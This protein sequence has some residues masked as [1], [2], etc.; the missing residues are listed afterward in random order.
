LPWLSLFL[1]RLAG[2]A[3]MTVA[4][5]HISRLAVARR[6][7]LVRLPLY[8]LL[9]SR[10]VVHRRMLVRLHPYRLLLSRVVVAS[11]AMSIAL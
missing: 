8:R 2:A 6:R 5:A 1:A 4:V 3:V 9:L 10:A 7:L 11:K